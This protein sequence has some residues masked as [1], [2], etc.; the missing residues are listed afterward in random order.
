MRDNAETMGDD[1]AKRMQGTITEHMTNTEATEL[2]QN[3]EFLDKEDMTEKY[4][5]KPGQ[6]E[7]I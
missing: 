3:N 1:L 6:L 7:P 4:K 2:M 5:D